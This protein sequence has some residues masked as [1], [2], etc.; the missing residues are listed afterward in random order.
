MNRIVTFILTTTLITMLAYPGSAPSLKVAGTARVGTLTQA[1]GGGG[2]CTVATGSVFNENYEGTGY[3]ESATGSWTETNNPNEDASLPG[4][5]PCSGLGSQ[6]TFSSVTTGTSYATFDLGSGTT[7][8]RYFRCYVYVDSSS[9]GDAETHT[10]MH[11]ESSGGDRAFSIR[12]KYDLG[13]GGSNLCFDGLGSSFTG[14]SAEV[15]LDTWYRVE[16][17]W[18]NNSTGGSELKIFNASSGTQVGSTL[19]FNTDTTQFQKISLGIYAN[20]ATKAT[21]FYIDG[22]GIDATG[23]LGQ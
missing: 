1:G 8:T 19:T 16:V 10:F 13:I 3:D 18:V 17:K 22:F 23:Y 21:D 5:S 2:G 9:L 4:T 6:C 11:A 15:Q 20:G 14:N 7:S 12:F